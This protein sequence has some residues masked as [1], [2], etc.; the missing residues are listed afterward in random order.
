[1]IAAPERSY[2]LAVAYRIYPKVAK[3]ALSLP[4]GDNKYQLSQVCLKS[5][6]ESLGRL[7]VKLWVLLDGCPPEYEELFRKYIDPRDLVILRLNGEGN[8]ATFGRQIDIL[9]QQEDADII[10]FAEDDYFYLPNQ[11]H[12]MIKFLT[13]QSGVDFI[14][15]YDH[16]DCYTLALHRG[17]K[18]L[19]VHGSHHWRTAASTCLTFLTRKETLENHEHVFRSYARGNYDCALWLSVTKHQVFNPAAMI[20]Y[21]AQGLFYWKILVKAWLYGW[22]QILF[23]RKMKLWVPVPAIATHLDSNSLS[24][25]VDWLAL[26]QREVETG[27]LIGQERHPSGVER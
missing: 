14:S 17:T 20:R 2:D 18:W 1:M 12:L 5:F 10:Y 21:F 11:F 27:R 25:G 16:L 3:C 19:R 6:R 24:P 15:P 22:R 13:T 9:L 26:I 7:R 8:H 23:G 4:F